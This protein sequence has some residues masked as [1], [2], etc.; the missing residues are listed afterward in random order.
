[1]AAVVA[2]AAE[3][4]LMMMAEVALAAQQSKQLRLRFLRPTGKCGGCDD[5]VIREME[6]GYRAGNLSK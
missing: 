4:A 3:V 5:G 6:K 1:V 2:V